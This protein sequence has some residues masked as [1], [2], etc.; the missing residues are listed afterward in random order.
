MSPCG[1]S[2]PWRQGHDVQ[3]P[4]LWSVPSRGAGDGDESAGLQVPLRLCGPRGCWFGLPWYL[5][6]VTRGWRGMSYSCAELCSA[7]TLPILERRTAHPGP[8][9]RPVKDHRGHARRTQGRH[10]QAAGSPF[11]PQR[12]R[13]PASSLPGQNLP[14]FAL[15]G[16]ALIVQRP[17]SCSLCAFKGKGY[18]LQYSR[19]SLLAQL[20]KNPPVVRET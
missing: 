17:V 4:R 20:V 3:A 9:H 5:P 6:W 2:C 13:R 12:S 7:S 19:A 16:G 11:S 18:P 8:S 14:C 10:F 1:E 15:R